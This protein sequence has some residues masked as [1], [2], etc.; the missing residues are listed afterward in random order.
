MAQKRKNR[1]K[2]VFIL[3]I[4]LFFTTVLFATSSYA[5]FTANKTVKVERISVNVEAK[6]GIQI[7]V[8]ALNWKS[9]IQKNDIVN[10]TTTYANAVNQ[11]PPKMEPVSTVG[12]LDNTGKME[13]Y[14]GTVNDDEATGNYYLTADKTTEVAT[15][16]AQLTAGTGEGK[17]VAF[18]LF[19]KVNATTP[20]QLRPGSG[21]TA[22][23]NDDTGIKNAAR[24]AFVILGRG[25]N[26]VAY[27]SLQGLGS[28][29]S[30]TDTREVK[31]W[32]PNYDVHKGPAITHA[33]STYKLTIPETA[34][35]QVKYYGLKAEIPTT[36]NP[37]VFLQ[38]DMRNLN[39]QLPANTDPIPD[40]YKSQYG[41]YFG[42]VTCVYKTAAAFSGGSD[43]YDIF[44]LTAGVTKV[45][46]YMWIE[47]QDV[48]CENDA[49]GGDINFD[50]DI[51]VKQTS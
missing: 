13:M 34:G 10:A 15:T 11:I 43:N 31:I 20:L 41:D 2:R 14:Y 7:S 29:T 16:S 45:R 50:L 35:S 12:T 51:T 49:S 42:D 36:T 32:E 37:K 44:T 27:T 6:N 23:N 46:I 21:V 40:D 4:A 25:D 19:F 26:N 18:D 24:I 47:G 3:I 9:L 22:A 1:K 17:F 39:G 28:Y 5:W 33:L 48:D 8:D 30:G 38:T